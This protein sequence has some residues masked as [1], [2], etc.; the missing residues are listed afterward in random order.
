MDIYIWIYMDIYGYIWIYMVK[1]ISTVGWVFKPTYDWARCVR[2]GTR[3][4][5]LGLT[6]KAPLYLV[7]SYVIPRPERDFYSRIS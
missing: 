2:E 1:N 6:G 3:A 4:V 7:Y 5:P